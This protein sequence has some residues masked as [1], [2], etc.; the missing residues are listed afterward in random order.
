[1]LIDGDGGGGLLEDAF[2]VLALRRLVTPDRLLALP[3]YPL[4]LCGGGGSVLLYALPLCAF[5]LGAP[6]LSRLL[7]SLLPLPA[8]QA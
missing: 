3:L 8:K 1:M 4:L 5:Q 2:P 7:L 6:P